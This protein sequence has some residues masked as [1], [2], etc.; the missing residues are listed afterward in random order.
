[1]GKQDW[2]CEIC[3]TFF[4]IVYVTSHSPSTDL[5]IQDLA[6]QI[7]KLQ[8]LKTS[9]LACSVDNSN[10]GNAGFGN[11][12][13]SWQ[14][15][16]KARFHLPILLLK[17][18]NLEIQDSACRILKFKFWVNKYSKLELCSYQ[19][20]KIEDLE[21]QDLCCQILKIQDLGIQDLAYEILKIHDLAA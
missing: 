17:I 9:D 15:S 16:K 13:F 5:K 19:I 1:M 21:T 12:R 8:D 11:S 20:L 3:Q 14:L 6:C 7:W 18:Q 10:V 2:H 4:N